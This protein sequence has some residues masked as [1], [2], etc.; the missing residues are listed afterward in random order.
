M[1]DGVLRSIHCNTLG[2]SFLSLSDLTVTETVW[3]AVG[4]MTVCTADVA[5][6]IAHLMSTYEFDERYTFRSVYQSN[7]TTNSNNRC[8]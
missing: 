8:L 5:I 7:R 4:K 6:L 1:Y 3:N 2:S